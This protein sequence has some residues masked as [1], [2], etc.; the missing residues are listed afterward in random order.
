VH[1]LAGQVRS[2]PWLSQYEVQ[3]VAFLDTIAAQSPPVFADLLV[4]N[5][6]PLP[7]EQSLLLL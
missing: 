6:L 4:V 5:F 7:K 2:L 1:R 3:R